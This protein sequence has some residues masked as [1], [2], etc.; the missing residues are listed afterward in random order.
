MNL[1]HAAIART[2]NLPIRH[3]GNV[4]NG[5]VRSVYWL[6]PEDSRGLIRRQSYC[7]H[8]DTPLGAMVISDR[9]SAYEIVWQG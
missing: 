8:P 9:I 2:D 7:I 5:K 6:T 3:Q 1:A 4:L